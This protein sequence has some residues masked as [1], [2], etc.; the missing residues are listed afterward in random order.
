MRLL[1]TGG[2][3]FVGAHFCQ[4]A[5]RVHEVVALHHS[6]PLAL[7]GVTPLRVDL[8]RQRDAAQ[9][10]GVEPDA[11][12]HI[13]CKIKARP[14][15]GQTGAEAAASFNRQMMDAV[16]SL[17][18]PVVY[19]SSTV[20]HWARD[21]PYA[22]SRKEDEQRLADSGLPYAI[23]RPS[24]PYGPALANH[25]PSHKESFHTLVE[26]VRHAPLVPV[27]GDGQYRR[28]PIHVDD[29]S[30]AILALLALPELPCAAYDAGG[31]VPLTFDE[32]ID[33]I[34]EAMGKRATKLHLPKALFVQMARFSRDFD[35]SLL[36]AMDEDEVAD[37][38][39]MVAATG[40]SPRSFRVGVTT[41][42]R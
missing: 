29:F 32:I 31:P 13:A 11:I 21:T 19:A 2:S 10:A 41:L 6:T 42:L 7:N 30:A 9:L 28:Q 3:S 37:P 25:R 35:P 14:K 33:T 12:V 15:D 39:A 27:V 36:A 5:A 4:Q 22:R 18:K 1:V 26:L 34:G 38:S 40:V 24:A 20:V 16:L 17:G 8:R 23:L